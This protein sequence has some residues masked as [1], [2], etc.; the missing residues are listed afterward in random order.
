MVTPEKKA[1]TKH[2]RIHVPTLV[3]LPQHNSLVVEVSE[4]AKGVVENDFRREKGDLRLPSRGLLAHR[5]P[6]L[7]CWRTQSQIGD[8]GG[9]ERA[10]E[11]GGP[12]ERD[13]RENEEAEE[14]HELVPHYFHL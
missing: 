13:Q 12:E 11:Q 4:L 8:R 2:V 5:R 1:S 10:G 7:C 6:R 14:G 3:I 9:E